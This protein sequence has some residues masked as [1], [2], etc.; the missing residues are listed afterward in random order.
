MEVF[1]FLKRGEAM[2]IKAGGKYFLYSKEGNKRL[3]GPYEERK[4]AEDREEQVRKI[5]HAK[6]SQK[7]KK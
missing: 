4:Q 5:V 1:G 7:N 6:L 2:I 3:G